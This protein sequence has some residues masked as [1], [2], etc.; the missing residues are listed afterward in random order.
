MIKLKS[1][2]AAAL[3]SVATLVSNAQ[4]EIKYVD[5]STL[6]VIVKPKPTE[7]PF[8]RID[9]FDF[10]DNG[11][12]RKIQHSTGL[13]VLFKTNSTSIRATWTTGSACPANLTAIGQKGLDLYIK[14]DGEWR[15]AGVGVPKMKEPFKQHS[16]TLIEKMDDSEKECLLYLPLYDRVDT[17]LLGFDAGATVE[18]M[19]NPFKYNIIF[20]GSSITHGAS[21]GRPGLCYTGLLETQYGLYCMNMGFSGNSKLQK[22]LAQYMAG[23]EN[24][25]AFVLDAFS[26]PSAAEI[27]SRFDEFVDILRASHPTTPIIFL[28]TE[29]R[30]T[31][32]FNSYK[33]QF[34]ADKQAAAKKCV[35][36]RMMDD[37][38]IYFIDSEGFLPTKDLSTTDGTH[39]NDY[40]MIRT[41]DII[42]PQIIDI[43][44]RKHDP[45]VEDL[46]SKM[47]LEEKV[48]QLV[49]MSTKGD[50]TGPTSGVDPRE[51]IRAGRCGNVFNAVDPDYIRQLQDIAVKESRLGIPLLFGY[52]EI[53]GQ[54][55]V[56]PICLGESC[57][58][59][60]GLIERS[61]RIGATEAAA[62][63]LNWTYNP[64]VDICW[65]PR[66]GRI[67]EGAGEDP[68]YGAKV[69][70]AR[71][72][73]VQGDDL[74][75]PLTIAAC[76]K[77]YAAYGAA[78]AGRDYNTVDMS[79]RGFHEFYLPPYRAAVEAGVASVMTSFNEFNGIPATANK[80]LLR[81][82]LRNEMGFKGFVVTDY[83]SLGE[84]VSHGYSEDMGQASVQAIEAGVDMDMAGYS[85]AN[86][87]V[88]KVR[89]GEVSI[90]LVNNAVRRVLQAKCDLGLFDDPYRYMDRKRYEK[91]T[92]C[93]EHREGALEEARASMVLLKNEGNALPLRKGEKIALIGELAVT[94]RNYLGT[95]CGKGDAKLTESVADVFTKQVGKKNV[96]WAKGCN[97]NGKGDDSGFAEALAAAGNADKIVIMM[98]EP[99]GWSGEAACR[100]DIRIPAI[101]T[102]LLEE[103]CKLG[104]P[105]VAVL[106][107][108]RP[109][110]LSRESELAT[111]ILECWYPG[112]MGAEALLDVLYGRYNPS[113]HL[114]ASF[115][116]TVGQL[117]F[118]YYGKSTGRPVGVKKNRFTSSYIDCPN[119]PLYPFGYG[120]SYTTFSYSPVSLSS[121]RMSADGEISASVTVTNT[122]D[123]F[124]ET[125]VQL[126]L[127]DLVGSVTRPVKMLRGFEKI[128]LKPGESRTVTFTV[129]EDMLKFWR[130]DMNYG[131]EPGKFH[132]FIGPD[133]SV[134]DFKEFTLE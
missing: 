24:V 18:A 33:E 100:T 68:W 114:T 90:T 27:E 102:R 51:D 95:W 38:N 52:D 70:A 101:Q 63:G 6:T 66:W 132:L 60:L 10:K 55:T 81:D 53:H 103:L 47:T 104:K 36:R 84:M 59:D 50:I 76:V 107:N 69:A 54:K 2:L 117:P 48:G 65:D 91:L 20:E 80:F 94:P 40:A 124:G 120:L 125:V 126:Y 83:N 61:A 92:Y 12:N 7:K 62:S 56:F 23:V 106:M 97:L 8:Q 25:D 45:R 4:N 72:H 49:L 115:P 86:N 31:R 119:T 123:V 108:G 26:N 74:S 16:G 89:S 79:E 122:G 87:L 19:P 5:A 99:F 88:D 133:S 9:G 30:E 111:S 13:A 105:V 3:L 112:S 77:H 28:Q 15:F 32:N 118:C 96:S 75:D 34:E 41:V 131:S 121:D 73:G 46:L 17:L 82:V 39:P 42:A 11:I 128:G 35:T 113:G 116:R 1:I 85:Y 64:M 14:K 130:A 43:L 44:E 29:T 58:W 93:K 134:S 110:D 21:A 37:A 129:N 22:E 98:G 71:V 57:S 109:L 127:R 67:S 78:A